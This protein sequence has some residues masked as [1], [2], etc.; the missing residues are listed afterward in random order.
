MNWGAGQGRVPRFETV[1][2]R[3]AK[4]IGG[5]M[6]ANRSTGTKV[7]CEPGQFLQYDYRKSKAP[8]EPSDNGRLSMI[9]AVQWNI[10]RGY[11]LDEIIATLK[12]NQAD[13]ICLQ[14]LDIDCERTN[15]RNVPQEI[16]EALGMNCVYVTEFVEFRSPKRKKRV[17]VSLVVL[18]H[19]IHEMFCRAEEFM[20][21]LYYRTMI[22]I[23][24]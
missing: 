12:R 4:T 24:F 2:A 22:W 10:E 19:V 16:A 9:K 1:S 20:E 21:M 17:Q 5:D 11:Q 23:R 6:G 13:I 14:E 7:L 18:L 3:A 8:L 15:N